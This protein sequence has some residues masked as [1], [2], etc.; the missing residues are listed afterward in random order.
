MAE[1]A[2]LQNIN[3]L[4]QNVKCYNLKTSKHFIGTIYEVFSEEYYFDKGK[5]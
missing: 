5:N 3:N 2:T 4:V 1:C